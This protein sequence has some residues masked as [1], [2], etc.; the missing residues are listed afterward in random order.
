MSEIKAEMA[1]IKV[2][3]LVRLEMSKEVAAHLID[4]LGSI[5]RDELHTLQERYRNDPSVTFAN[6]RTEDGQSIAEALYKSLSRAV[7]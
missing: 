1:E 4:L 3:K 2:V 7:S 5:S 6:Y